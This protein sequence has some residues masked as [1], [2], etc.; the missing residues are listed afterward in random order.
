MQEVCLVI[1]CYNEEQ[2]LK[3]DEILRFLQEQPHVHV[4]LVNDGSS[5]G[6]LE[7]LERLKTSDPGRIA[8]VSLPTNSGKAEAVRQGV[9]HTARSKQFALIGYWDADLSTPFPEL[10]GL[11]AALAA[12]PARQLALGSRVKRLGAH[13][14]RRGSRHVL[15]RVFAT[16]ASLL[17]GLPVYDSQ[18]GAKLFRAEA[19]EILFS[20][21]FV[22]RWLFD[23]EIIAR[24][25]K[26]LGVE[27]VLE[28]TVEVPL[29]T[30]QEVGGSKL[31]LTHMIKVPFDLLRISLHYRQLKHT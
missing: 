28:A 30:W 10:G 5:D 29:N 3:G 16:A 20:E 19:V 18:C 14:D 1:P 8:V 22:T 4:C 12:D 11:V 21:Q 9:M 13:I 2:R 15:G 6:T 23:I 27:G 26:S 25:C 17:L 7:M 24:L 31:R